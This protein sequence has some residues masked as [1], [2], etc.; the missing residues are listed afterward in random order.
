MGDFAY[1]PVLLI[2]HAGM[3]LQGNKN[4]QLPTSGYSNL[5]HRLVS[6]YE[7]NLYTITTHHAAPS[8]F[9]QASLR[10]RPPYE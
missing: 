5:H 3:K 4:T 9:P 8:P 6:H 2:V 10:I 1:T 7:K